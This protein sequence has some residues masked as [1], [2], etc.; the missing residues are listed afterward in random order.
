MI[1]YR[2]VLEQFKILPTQFQPEGVALSIPEAVP[3]YGYLM[4]QGH[5]LFSVRHRT[6][7]A[8]DIYHLAISQA[9]K[10]EGLISA[11]YMAGK[12]AYALGDLEQAILHLKFAIEFAD[13]A[14]TSQKKLVKLSKIMRSLA[15]VYRTQYNYLWLREVDNDW[16][17]PRRADEAY[18]SSDE[19]YEESLLVLAK[20]ARKGTCVERY[21]VE[22]AI[23]TSHQALLHY[24]DACR[25]HDAEEAREMKTLARMQLMTSSQTMTISLNP[26]AELDC[27]V[28]TLRASRFRQRLTYRHRLFQL[29]APGTPLEAERSRALAILLLGRRVVRF[30]LWKIVEQ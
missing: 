30:E 28:N 17:E 14:Y 29:T 21:E 1:L 10:T 27:L 26:R 11:H 12:S 24:L 19:W 13:I 23:T 2:Y 3:S 15:T 6:R 5:Y 8:L 18:T 16:D 4:K 22:L 7:D 25:I 9:T 20:A